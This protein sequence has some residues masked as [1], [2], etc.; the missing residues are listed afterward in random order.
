MSRRKG[1][2]VKYMS[3]DQFIKAFQ[4]NYNRVF[5]Y[6]GGSDVQLTISIA[7]KYT[8]T[9]RQFSGVLLQKAIEQIEE[10]TKRSFSIRSIS[11]NSY[12]FAFYLLR[13]GDLNEAVNKLVRNDAAL[14]K[15][16]FKNTSYRVL[17]ALFLQEDEMEHAQ[18]AKRLFDEMNRNQRILTSKEDIPYAVYL[19]SNPDENP[20]EQADT[21]VRYYTYLRKNHFTMGNHLQALAQIMTIYK[22]DYNETLLRYV[23]QLREELIRRNI[24]VKKAHYP[25]LGVLAL[26]ATNESKIDEIVSLHNQ[27]LELKVFKSEKKYALI[28][29]IQKIVQDLVDVQEMIDMTPLTKITELFDTVDFML[30]L[31]IHFPTGISDVADF[32]N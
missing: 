22:S 4:D 13:Q 24:K 16:K 18:R 14:E 17:G 3:N 30:D 2:G 23:V 25:F 19:T 21:I 20:K 27:L 32:F 11:K 7:C 29:A 5:N 10:S 26:A 1:W 9:K 28:V 12:K 6:T 15:V 31:G 8:L